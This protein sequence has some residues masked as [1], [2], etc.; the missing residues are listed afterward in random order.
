MTDTRLYRRSTTLRAIAL[1]L[2]LVAGSGHRFVLASNAGEQFHIS[3]TGSSSTRSHSTILA[4][5]KAQSGLV[6]VAAAGGV[7]VYDGHRVTSYT[8]WIDSDGRHRALNVSAMAQTRSGIL[9]LAT[10]GS[11]LLAFDP[12]TN[13]FVPARQK[14]PLNTTADDENITRVFVDG[15]GNV[16]LGL[17][18]GLVTSLD[19]AAGLPGSYAKLDSPVADITEEADGTVYAL[20]TDGQLA[21]F[22]RAHPTPAI[23]DLKALCQPSLHSLTAI[24]PLS[25]STVL[26]GTRGDGLYL[27]DL[28]K[29]KCRKEGLS[30]ALAGVIADTV[31]H[32]IVSDTTDDSLWI[33]T[34]RGLFHRNA[35][36]ASRFHQRNSDISNNEVTSL[37]SA[38][39]G[40]LWIGT[41]AGLNIGTRS[42]FESV[43]AHNQ[44]LLST[45]FAI[46]GN[47]TLG[48]WIAT[49]DNLFRED[50]TTGQLTPIDQLF[51]GLDAASL[52]IM[53]LHVHQRY[54]YIGTRNRGL[55]VLDTE[56]RRRS[57]YH[58]QSVPGLPSNSVS[59][60]LTTDAG[61]LLVGT[62]GAGL[63]VITLWPGATRRTA[64]V[65]TADGLLHNNVTALF[66]HSDGRL[67]VA[68][69]GGLQ[70]FHPSTGAFDDVIFTGESP[71]HGTV[72]AL[73]LTEDSHGC[74]WI[75]TYR[76]GLFLLDTG[77]G[78]GQL[79]AR[80]V[81]TGAP[82]SK[83]VYALQAD[84][85]GAVWASTN[86]GLSR[87]GPDLSVHN[88]RYKHGLQGPDFEF[89]ASYQATSGQIYFGGSHGYNRF[90]PAAFSLSSQPAP[91][92]LTGITI[93]GKAR[94]LHTTA[95][96]PASI[97]LSHA[98]YYV[99]F[100]F[101]ALDYVD[102]DSNL[103]RYKLEGFDPDWVSIGN[104]S[105]ATYTN[106]PP[107]NYQ[108][109]VQAANSNGVWNF[110]GASLALYVSPPP[111]R[112]WW[113]WC[114]YAAALLLLGR[115]AKRSY[116][117]HIIHRATQQ[118]ATA[119]ALTADRALDDAQEQLEEQAQLVEA[120]H[121]FNLV[122]LTLLREC[123]ARQA[124]T[125]PPPEYAAL[126]RHIC[127][128]LSAMQCL[129]QAL[130]YCHEELL[131]N[132][133]S[134]TNDLAQQLEAAHSAGERIVL[135][136]DL[137]EQLLP[138][139]AA[140]PLSIILYELLENAYAHAFAA[141]PE[142]GIVIVR[143]HYGDAA[144]GEAALFEIVDNGAGLPPAVA[145]D[146]PASPGL[147]TVAELVRSL[148]GTLSVQ[149][150][151]GTHYSLRV[152]AIGRP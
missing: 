66:R 149:R 53:S 104:R 120:I 45:V 50:P 150:S 129:E 105:S 77:H 51:P 126:Q 134:Y 122:R 42:L 87:I 61:E 64:V 72:A 113:A 109:R 4:I 62:H 36:Q 9:L 58:S 144:K 38:D 2:L 68:S 114:L 37:L 74:L 70:V 30:D 136:N 117:R 8:D 118:R 100:D 123:L 19:E 54:L 12:A 35:G 28:S 57:A 147:A 131:A 1:L 26:L 146:T 115:Q 63:A 40:L 130:R 71:G 78:P 49:Y 127:G 135:V 47:D 48:T 80:P 73:S 86:R 90:D 142:G 76:Q 39:S 43:T 107:G 13:G 91:V 24:H 124:K 29:G 31:V 99:T 17:D 44:P 110:D 32:D 85:S 95:Q 145:I 34:D 96:Q 88:F 33:G 60:I 108:F 138:A 25:G 84:N 83:T 11:G 81:T 82:I 103:Y 18:S 111:W 14:I 3:P 75:G 52:G 20:G 5:V 69:E 27:Q 143:A 141:F 101:S 41:Y 94:A 139:S 10:H 7:A 15:R 92:V 6:W 59:A 152:P 79:T 148:G 89:G 133:H 65:D 55:V 97:E 119:L 67:F 56:R 121:Q 125:L 137:P 46:D 106:L 151:K 128:R 23:V 98:D 112:Q 132:L 102:P 22:S 16:W 140:L 93:A 116:D 21:I